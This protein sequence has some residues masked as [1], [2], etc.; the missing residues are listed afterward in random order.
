MEEK[1][2]LT[3]GFSKPELFIDGRPIGRAETMTTQLQGDEDDSIQLPK[4]GSFSISFDIP[5]ISDAFKEFVQLQ[6]VAKAQEML[7]RLRDYQHLWRKY[8][9]FGMR[10]ERRQIERDFKALAQR[11]AI[12]C[13]NYGITIQASNPK[14]KSDHIKDTLKPK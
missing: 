9:G 3:Q 5:A 6:P 13:R 14:E 4:P 7:N 1:D 2:N 10:R 11:L 12:H 8:Y